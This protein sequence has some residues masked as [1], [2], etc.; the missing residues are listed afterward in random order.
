LALKPEAEFRNRTSETVKARPFLAAK[1][2]FVIF[3]T[4]W[5]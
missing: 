3:E 2:I 1:N 5:R 4:V